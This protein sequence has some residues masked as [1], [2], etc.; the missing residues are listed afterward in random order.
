MKTL[1]LLFILSFTQYIT[2]SPLPNKPIRQINPHSH[3]RNHPRSV[4]PS[5]QINDS[6]IYGPGPGDFCHPPTTITVTAPGPAAVGGARLEPVTSTVTI[7]AKGVNAGLFDELL[8]PINIGQSVKPEGVITVTME[9][10]TVILSG[11]TETVTMRVT[12]SEVTVT[13]ETSEI[14]V[15]V[16]A[17]NVEDVPGTITTY[18]TST[19]TVKGAVN[20]REAMPTLNSYPIHP[21]VQKLCSPRRHE[22]A[23]PKTNSRTTSSEHQSRE[24]ANTLIPLT[25]AHN[26]S[27]YSYRNRRTFFHPNLP[28]RDTYGTRLFYYDYYQ[29]YQYQGVLKD[30]RFC[31]G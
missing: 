11:S 9:T 25:S 24:D 13:G 28:S 29:G 3:Y 22:R 17:Q 20:T 4:D 15:T 26:I 16:S 30:K 21:L 7:T 31:T 5:P 12:G 10:S 19:I 8:G 14:T 2:S 27:Q 1:Q 6:P 18:S 23:S